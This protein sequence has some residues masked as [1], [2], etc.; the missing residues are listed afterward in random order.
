MA[1]W[2]LG[3][4]ATEHAKAPKERIPRV[5]SLLKWR[6]SDRRRVPHT[7]PYV[8]QFMRLDLDAQQACFRK[9]HQKVD[10]CA[11]VVVPRR[12]IQRV[13]DSTGIGSGG[14]EIEYVP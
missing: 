3:C 12:K 8:D 2:N 13:N 4:T 7:V 9:N 6:L 10:L 1:R 14:E 5:R 11:P